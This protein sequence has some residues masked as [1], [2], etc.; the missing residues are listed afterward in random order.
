L[1][2]VGAIGTDLAFGAM[3]LLPWR[4]RWLW[5]AQIAVVLTYTLIITWRLPLLWLEPFGPVAKNLPILALLLL[6]QQ[7]E[8]RK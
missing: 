2:L 4:P 5:P 6:L 7:L 3:T 1:L 8:E